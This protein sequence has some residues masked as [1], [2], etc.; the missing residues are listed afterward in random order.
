MAQSMDMNDAARLGMLWLD[1]LEWRT[2]DQPKAA[3]WQGEGWYGGDYNKAWVRTEGES[4]SGRSEAA[5]A[6]L[7][8]DHVVARWWN[9]Q[10]GGRQDFGAGPARSWAALGLRGRASQG[11]DV[12]ATVY[13]GAASRTAARL[14]IQYELLFTQ[15]LVLQPE[16]EMNLYGRA[17]PARDIDAGVAD[18]EVGLRLRYEL[19]REFAPYAGVVWARHYGA[20]ADF[21]RG[22]SAD[23]NE[24]RLAVG[25]R[26]WL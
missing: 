8:W 26:V 2:V 6:E 4:Y 13:A 17:D 12:E 16:M 20:T 9:L 25:L 7:F 3:A 15:R 24:L 14:K 5:R 22:G 11:F 19:R 21:P 1:Q 10:V 18:F 23:P